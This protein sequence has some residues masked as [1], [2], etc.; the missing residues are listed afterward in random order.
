[1][2]AP[3]EALAAVHDAH[4]SYQTL[5]GLMRTWT[6]RSRSGQAFT[7][8]HEERTRRIKAMGGISHSSQISI[9]GGSTPSP[10][11]TEERHTLWVRRPDDMRV[12]VDPSAGSPTAGSAVLARE[13]R[14]W[15]LDQAA[16]Q[17][18]TGSTNHGSL[19]RVGALCDPARLLCAGSIEFAGLG[20]RAG[21]T[22]AT[23]ILR[24]VPSDPWE[25]SPLMNVAPGGATSYVM[26]IDVERGVALRL[27]ALLDED[28]F[29]VLELEEVEFDCV[30]DPAL[31]EPPAQPRDVV[32]THPRHHHVVMEQATQLAGFTIFELWP[33]PE[34]MENHNTVSVTLPPLHSERG[35]TH[36][37]ACTIY[38]RIRPHIDNER[39][40]YVWQQP[41]DAWHA[42]VPA[43]WW[44][45]RIDVDGQVVLVD[46]APEGQE[47]QGRSVHLER[48]GTR[49]RNAGQLPL[50]ELLDAARRLRPVPSGPPPLLEEP[51]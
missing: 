17:W 31:F 9:M 36:A 2:T 16:D 18:W 51:T 22:C 33:P 43:G 46:H 26:D 35:W 45:E 39:Q 23:L 4:S 5:R 1:M 14:A 12:E 38:T 47:S 37:H 29:F 30:L 6:H 8:D 20:H 27:A 48:H 11:T 49:L 28:E 7:R 3:G 15:W 44:L 41:V 34:G 21:R 40:I 24:D 19:I 10:E 50:E 13:G 25:P 42:S 32:D